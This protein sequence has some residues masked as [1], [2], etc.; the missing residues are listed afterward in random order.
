MAAQP[1]CCPH[2]GRNNFTTSRAFSQHIS[3]NQACRKQAAGLNGLDAGYVTAQ[4]FLSCMPILPAPKRHCYDP[5]AAFYGKQLAESRA[6][7]AQLEED[8]PI[9][10]ALPEEDEGAYETAI[11]EIDDDDYPVVMGNNEE[12]SDSSDIPMAPNHEHNANAGLENFK[13]YCTEALE[14]RP[15]TR[16]ERT[17]IELLQELRK[18]KA[19]L[20]TYKAVMGWHLKASGA[21]HHA[22]D[23]GKSAAYL[24]P[25]KIYKFLRARYNMEHG[26]N[27][28]KEIILSSS[29]AKAK[30]VYSEA[31][32][33]LQ[34]L[35]SDPRIRDE[36]YLFFDPE[37]PF[38]PPPA[39]LNYISDINTG[40]AYLKT[41]KKLIT[42]PSKQ[43][44]LPII[45]YIDGAETGQFSHLPITAFKI[46]LGIFNRK[47]RD[48]G[49]LWRTLGYLP[50]TKALEAIGHRFL[51]ESGHAESTRAYHEALRNEGLITGN[52]PDKAQDLHDM[53]AVILKSFVKL[54]KSGFKW[55][56]RYRGK[57]YKDVEFIPFVPFIM[58]DTDEA[59]KHCGKF[60][61]RTRNIANLCRFCTCPT[62]LSDDPRAHY[63]LKTWK[64]IRA[65][66]KNNNAEGLQS[67][68]Q[69]S[70]KN[71]WWRVQF[72]L[73]NAQGIHGACPF[74]MLHHIL[75]GILKAVR[76]G[77]FEQLGQESAK[78]GNSI[79]G[80]FEGLAEQYGKLLKRHSV[81]DMPKLYFANGISGGKLMAK[82]HRGIILLIAV[83]MQSSK[84]RAI[85]Q[86]RRQFTNEHVEDW[87]MLL[88]TLLQWESW[89]KNDVMERKHV[90]ALAEKNR[91]L[92]YLIWKVGRKT[93]GMGLKTVKFHGITHLAQAIIDFGVPINYDTSQVESHHKP[94]KQA[95]KLTQKKKTTFDAQTAQRLQEMDLLALASE[96]MK[97]R[98][99]WEYWAGHDHD[100]VVAQDSEDNPTLGGEA[101]EVVKG[102]DGEF[103]VQTCRRIKGKSNKILLEDQF[104]DFFGGLKELVEAHI[105]D[106]KV[107]S[108]HKR[109]GTIFRASCDI[110]GGVWR[111]WVVVDWG[112]G[113]GLLPCKLWGFVDLRDLPQNSGILYGGLQ[114]VS[115]G[116]YAIVESTLQ[117]DVDD[118]GQFVR[119]ISLDVAQMEGNR[120]TELR[121]YLADCEAFVD[122]AV[123]VPNIGGPANSY[124]WVARPCDWAEM[125]ESWLEAPLEDD[126]YM[127][128]NEEIEDDSDDSD[129]SSEE[130][131]ETENI[132]ADGTDG[133]DDGHDGDT[134]DNDGTSESEEDS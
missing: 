116:Q 74:E 36:D 5:K 49:Y 26:Y 6:M 115:P 83:T 8:R 55:W 52:E 41:W 22:K 15:F 120:V 48:K 34:S 87:I 7:L 3:R 27:I 104:I 77:F 88:Q 94:G 64:K 51:I 1:L 119:Q 35:L 86:N 73:H 45:P 30:V 53:V 54:Q 61:V 31:H 46:T 39:H 10:M 114:H 58:A 125:F 130:G 50:S 124:F 66:I 107:L 91:R 56:L 118:E 37:D 129:T 100:A 78:K 2:C 69:K 133:E 96:E 82:E 40:Q 24:A 63:P 112:A 72:G 79:S 47:A 80:R 67:I 102:D 111:D 68:S 25:E 85:V 122:P 42:D 4:E 28:V 57:L 90:R 113:D 121:F 98:P 11:E 76:D 117:S 18:T 109:Q 14:F 110:W 99:L 84:G 62:L 12:S 17:A 71:A 21:I 95:A 29:K 65:L 101:L 128:E 97:G 106:L 126:D 32:M 131:S 23:V 134:S 127:T 16:K 75:L 132:E 81:R 44:L 108:Q 59:D 19:S 123:V 33:V 20:S 70:I 13:N 89:L 38:S 60:L 103:Q 105:P 92:M 43:I 93:K 9:N